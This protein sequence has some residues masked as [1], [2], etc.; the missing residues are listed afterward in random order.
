M[1]EDNR[2]TNRKKTHGVEKSDVCKE[3][4]KIRAEV[5]SMASHSINMKLQ[6]SD[7]KHR[8]NIAGFRKDELREKLISIIQ[9]II[10]C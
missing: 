1:C 5:E 7:L 6:Q 8:Y 2:Q 3:V 10:E 9:V 4:E